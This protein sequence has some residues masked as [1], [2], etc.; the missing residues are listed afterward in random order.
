[1]DQFLPTSV[2][3][4]DCSEN[5]RAYWADQLRSCSPEYEILEAADG[6]SGLDLFRSRRIDCVVTEL[7]LN[8]MSAFAVLEHLMPV[9]NRPQVAVIILTQL[10]Y[11]SLWD[12]AKEQGAY[13]CFHKHH[14]SG[15][16][17]SR[18]IQQALTFVRQIA[19][20]DQKQPAI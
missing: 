1:M 3:L 4:I 14:T 19:K 18:A 7:A 5:Q 16:D 15:E 10:A 20:E 11:R 2:L 13:A 12:L 17:L 6:P 9:A 8:D